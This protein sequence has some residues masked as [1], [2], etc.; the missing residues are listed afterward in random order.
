MS[1]KKTAAE[2]SLAKSIWLLGRADSLEEAEQI[3]K[4]IEQFFE[5]WPWCRPLTPYPW[6]V[7]DKECR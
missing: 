4:G 6:T 7:D 3:A 2:Q 5:Q 1:Q